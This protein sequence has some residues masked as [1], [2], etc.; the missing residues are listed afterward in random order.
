SGGRPSNSD[1]CAAAQ[2]PTDRVKAEDDYVVA[3]RDLLDLMAA[4]AVV[5]RLHQICPELDDRVGPDAAAWSWGLAPVLPDGVAAETR[6]GNGVVALPQRVECAPNDLHVLLRHRL[7]LPPHGFENVHT[8]R[9]VLDSDDHIVSKPVDREDLA[10][11]RDAA[12]ARRGA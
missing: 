11:D 3:A 4:D 12:R 9:V 6:L 10:G 5:E 2:S 8:L 1:R 7:P